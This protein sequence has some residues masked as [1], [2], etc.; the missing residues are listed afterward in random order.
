MSRTYLQIFV[1][2]TALPSLISSETEMLETSCAKKLK[3]FFLETT[4]NEDLQQCDTAFSEIWPQ[5]S[6]QVTTMKF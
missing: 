3:I 1:K 2:N 4:N 5:S 6:V